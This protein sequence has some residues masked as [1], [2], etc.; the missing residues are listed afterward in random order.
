[1]L[2]SVGRLVLTALAV[3]TMGFDLAAEANATHVWNPI[4][5]PHARFHIVWQL[6]TNCGLAMLALAM[7][8]AMHT[9]WAEGGGQ[10]TV[11][12]AAI[13]LILE[14]VGFWLAS[15]TR[16]SYGGTFF[17]ANVP[18]YDIEVAGI[19]VAAFVFLCVG[20][21]ELFVA[22]SVTSSPRAWKVSRI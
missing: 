7:L 20:L 21:V 10:E 5:E 9:T 14:P 4:I 8:W 18:E 12:F 1:M 17:P 3:F 19:P 22:V 15:A 16:G 2:P 13:L 11:R 6:A